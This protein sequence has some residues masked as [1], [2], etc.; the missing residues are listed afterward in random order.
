MMEEF[1]GFI[2]VIFW[3]QLIWRSSTETTTHTFKKIK[4]SKVNGHSL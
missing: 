1:S 2:T 3:K 4:S